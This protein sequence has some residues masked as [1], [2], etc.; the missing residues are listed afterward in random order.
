MQHRRYVCSNTYWCF[1]G[2]CPLLC[3]GHGDYINGE[4]ECHPGWKG[5]ECSLR[6]D[7]CEVSDCSGRGHCQDGKCQCMPGFTGDFCEQGNLQCWTISM[8]AYS[9]FPYYCHNNIAYKWEMC[10]PFDVH[11]HF[12]EGGVILCSRTLHIRKHNFFDMFI[13]L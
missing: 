1:A 4:C 2:A 3:G 10:P 11:A 9:L 5:K 7:E 13:L 6:H 8:H 12:Y